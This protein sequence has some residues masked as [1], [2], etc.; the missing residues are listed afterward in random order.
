MRLDRAIGG[1]ICNAGQ[2][3]T[4]LDLVIIQKALI[5]LVHAAGG[6][7]AS[8]GGTGPRS[9]GIGEVDALLFSC[10]ENVLIIGHVD[11]LVETFALADQSDLVGSHDLV[12]TNRDPL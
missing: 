4:S 9:T 1:W 3:E 11:G 10:I 8:T 6:E 5:R 2:H 12:N 7:L